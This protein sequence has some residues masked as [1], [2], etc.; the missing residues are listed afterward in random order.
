MI[1]SVGLGTTGV[2]DVMGQT[3]VVDLLDRL[4][5]LLESSTRIPFMNKALVDNLAALEIVDQI[6]ISLPE[7]V[8]QAEAML[9]EAAR[10]VGEAKEEAARTISEANERLRSMIKG[11]E[12]VKL[13]EEEAAATLER[14]REEA[15]GIRAGADEYA[16]QVLADLEETLEKIGKVIRHGR[17]EL[18]RRGA[19]G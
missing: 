8:K 6:R 14:A 3:K 1:R 17:E 10:V 16:D 15:R 13:A 12:I 4:E 2:V 9:A 5:N 19:G 18:G 11:T 7:S